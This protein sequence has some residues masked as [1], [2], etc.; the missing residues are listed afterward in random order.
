MAMSDVE[1]VNGHHSVTD[2]IACLRR[3]DLSAG[4]VVIMTVSV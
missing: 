1:T 2:A 4:V 3:F